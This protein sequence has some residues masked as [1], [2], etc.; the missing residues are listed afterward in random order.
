M[1]VLFAR[2]LHPSAVKSLERAVD[3]FKR[4][5]GGI[6]RGGSPRLNDRRELGDILN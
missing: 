2:S 1:G 6:D 5:R 3:A 4:G